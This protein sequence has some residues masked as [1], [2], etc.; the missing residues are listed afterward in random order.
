[1]LL[2]IIRAQERQEFVERL[3]FRSV[4][5]DAELMKEVAP[6]VDD[7]RARGDRALME[8]TARFDQIALKQFRI[9]EDELHRCAARVD[10]RVLKALREA[11]RNVRAF[12]SRQ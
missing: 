4:A 6:I 1:M 2:K 3:A 7:V 9:E 8:Y 5:L 10:E 12:H 11:I